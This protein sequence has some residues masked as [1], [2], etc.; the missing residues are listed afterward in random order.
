MAAMGEGMSEAKIG[1]DVGLAQENS[2]TLP[3]VSV[4]DSPAVS[5]A[6]RTD[7]EDTELDL[8]PPRPMAVGIGGPAANSH[9]QGIMRRQLFTITFATIGCVLFA[10]AVVLTTT[11]LHT[12]VTGQDR[13]AELIAVTD[14]Q[15]QAALGKIQNASTDDARWAAVAET[16]ALGRDA[17][18]K[19]KTQLRNGNFSEIAKVGI[20]RALHAL[21]DAGFAADQMIAAV[22]SFQNREARLAA[23]EMLGQV[24]SVVHEPRLV[25]LLDQSFDAQT[26]VAVAKAL[27]DACRET[28]KS[29][30][31]LRELMGSDMIGTR[32]DAALAY[33]Q[34]GR[35]DEVEDTLRLLADE[36]SH[37]GRLARR[38]LVQMRL[39]RQL[40]RIVLQAGGTPPANN[41]GQPA[42]IVDPE[43]STRIA[44]EVLSMVKERAAV[45][46]E[47]IADV[48]LLYAAA[49]QMLRALD[50]YNG[51]LTTPEAAAR[52]RAHMADV[53]NIA[54]PGVGLVIAKPAG[55]FRV[56]TTI[57]GSPAAEAGIRPGDAITEID[58]HEVYE[59]SIPQV[60]DLLHGE[61]GTTVDVKVIREGWFV[62]RTFHLTR[63]QIAAPTVG[64][65]MLPGGV[66]YIRIPSCI[67]G[68]H[69]AV[70]AGVKAL[71]AAG[72]KSLLLDVRGNPGGDVNETV[73]IAD[74]FLPADKLVAYTLGRNRDVASRAEFKTVTPAETDLPVV[75]LVDR[76]TSDAAEVLAGALQAHE[77]AVLVGDVREMAAEDGLDP[78]A[79][80]ANPNENGPAPD[81][82]TT[83]VT[84]GKGIVQAIIPLH[85][86]EKAAASPEAFKGS[87]IKLTIAF[88]YLPGDVLIQDRGLTPAITE[89][90]TLRAGWMLDEF[91]KR[92]FVEALAEYL[93]GLNAQDAAKLRE[94]AT[95][96]GRDAAKWPGLAELIAK[97]E[98]KAPASDV[99]AVVRA[100]A[101]H[102][103][104]TQ[105]PGLSPFAVDIQD[106]RALL[107]AC[108]AALEKAGV[109]ASGVPEYQRAR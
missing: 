19:I 58:G 34:T 65:L 37:R 3:V 45:E 30:P 26:K 25:N 52:A 107:R 83:G 8:A 10:I 51:F 69:A 88:Y 99:R 95:F 18:P 53:L 79:P 89:R 21:G 56:V 36:P 77:R 57:D 55:V 91:D 68:T 93:A 64:H 29:L 17:A 97:T 7:E 80:E 73:K 84:F 1:A 43:V 108:L 38:L 14:A 75:L 33:A 60:D 27:W 66:G 54:A 41:G 5:S 15:V 61:A 13:G 102:M 31:A 16:I 101:R 94:L 87:A 11:G 2:H 32:I 50:P 103:L 63:R 12:P 48:K 62:Q 39:Q 47:L 72:A 104:A 90:T 92:I 100:A 46:P 28:R 74:L 82:T 4:P 85:F 81:A 86:N 24:C 49:D 71:A 70:K 35:I 78:N 76:G 105:A 67:A 59:L 109:D 106:D 23:A 96:D 6:V 9:A 22:G 20:W 98:C 44:E 40:E 42:A